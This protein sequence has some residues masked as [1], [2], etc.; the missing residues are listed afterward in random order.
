MIDT[1]VIPCG[2]RGTRLAPAT[3]WIPKELLPVAL[4]PLLFWTL[5]EAV[6]AGLRRAIIVTSPDK[7]LVQ[8]AAAAYD[9]S[10]V[11][12]C[13][14]QSQ[15]RGLGDALCAAR[16]ALGGAPFTVLLPDNLFRGTNPTAAVLAT[17]RTT[18]LATV[19]L[20]EVTLEH[21][22]TK[23]PTGH[24]TV[25]EAPDGTLRITGI[26]EKAP[27]R[28]DPGPGGR[29]LT[30]IGR[31]A[32]DG[33]VFDEFDAVAAT[34]AAGAEL[35]DVPVLRRLAARR[36][37]AG[38]VCAGAFYDVGI[39]EGLRQAVAEFPA[40]VSGLAPTAGDVDLSPGRGGRV[41]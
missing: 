18:G 11:V 28:F 29:A 1:A 26:G 5:D 30:P 22:A 32:F 36:A 8:A 34:L 4:R 19:L 20:A 16:G 21:A 7:P 23:G 13:V 24:A 2:G 3:H 40:A 31:F 12:E 41:V 27:D 10:I 15:P 33:A 37:L 17:R 35:D 25:A 38:V 14:E 6:A 9:G 39:A